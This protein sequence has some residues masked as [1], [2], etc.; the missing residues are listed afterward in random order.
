MECSAWAF[1]C[2]LRM[3]DADLIA[4]GLHVPITKR[5][6]EESIEPAGPSFC[7]RDPGP[8]LPRRVVPSV[9]GMPALEVRY[10]VTFVVLVKPRDAPF[11][12]YVIQPASCST[13][14]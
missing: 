5:A 11:H 1:T 12:D 6:I 2:K 10:P 9:L 8:D 3:I 7:R 14:C 13:V 4:G